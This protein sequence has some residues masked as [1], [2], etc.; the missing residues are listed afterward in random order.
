M[1]NH[2]FFVTGIALSQFVHGAKARGL[3]GD[4]ALQRAGLRAEEHLRPSARIP[5]AQYVRVLLDLILASE[6][7]SLGA[8]VGQ[9]LMP[10]LYGVLMT[11]AFSSPTLGEALNELSHHAALASGN[12][13]GI[14]Y[15]REGEKAYLDV[16]IAHQNPVIRR[17]VAEFVVTQFSGLIRLISCQADLKPESVA[18]EHEPASERARQRLEECVACPVIWQAGTTHIELLA[19]VYDLPILGHGDETLQSARQLAARQLAALQQRSTA[20]EQIRW[21]TREL[22]HSGIPNRD[23]VAER[24]NLSVRSLDRRLKQAETSWQE[25]LDGLRAQLAR[26]YL[27]DQN[28]TVTQV[29]EKLG[30]A[31]LRAFQRRFKTWTGLTPSDWRN[32]ATA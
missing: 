31:D 7:E 13:G 24:L 32:Q 1:S 2:A 30:Y 14:D 19:P 28:L 12:C 27:A 11:L 23:M 29:A 20:L 5:E 17:Q 4:M 25:M 21:H 26:E 16:V 22:M 3:D 18:L 8:D 6:G 9:Q 10:P 15:R